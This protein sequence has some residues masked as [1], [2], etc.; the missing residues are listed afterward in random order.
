MKAVKRDCFDN[1]L[2]FWYNSQMDA[3]YKQGV[4]IG[5]NR[6]MEKKINVLGVELDNYQ[7]DEAMEMVGEY[8]QNDLLNTIGIVTMQMLLLADEDEQWKTYLKD[9]D[10]SIIG[11]TEI[12]TAA[13]IEEDLSL[14][15]I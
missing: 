9:L 1:S 10:M 15:H 11:E 2:F 12:L 5:S 3:K 6:E 4:A 14:I 13:G 7:V 8:M